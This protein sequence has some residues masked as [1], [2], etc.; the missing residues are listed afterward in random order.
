VESVS[1]LMKKDQLNYYNSAKNAFKH[2]ELFDLFSRKEGMN[3][4]VTLN[5]KIMTLFVH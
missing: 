4:R 2:E 1:V 5:L 3:V